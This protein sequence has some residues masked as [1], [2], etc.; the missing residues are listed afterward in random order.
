MNELACKGAASG[1]TNRN[2]GVGAAASR[3]G[4][5]AVSALRDG[6]HGRRQRRR[7]RVARLQLRDSGF[8]MFRVF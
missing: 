7:L 3:A 1:G 6:T 4:S 5:S 8:R 2:I